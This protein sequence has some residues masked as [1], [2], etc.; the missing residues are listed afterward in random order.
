MR[1]KSHRGSNPLLSARCGTCNIVA[2]SRLAVGRLARRRETLVRIQP[3]PNRVCSACTVPQQEYVAS[4]LK[5]LMQALPLDGERRSACASPYAPVAQWQSPQ[6]IPEKSQIGARSWFKSRRV[7]QISGWR[8]TV[9][10][11]T[12]TRVDQ[13][14]LLAL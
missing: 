14:R 7:Y 1:C 6:L 10:S 12:R 5:L 11:A 9:V 8:M 2:F 4:Y 3:E 13:V